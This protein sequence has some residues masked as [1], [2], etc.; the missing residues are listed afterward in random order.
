[1]IASP[2]VARG[3]EAQ[4]LSWICEF[5]RSLRKSV[6]PIWAV[7][8]VLSVLSDLPAGPLVVCVMA[9]IGTGV[10]LALRERRASALDRRPARQHCRQCG[11]VNRAE[12][13]R[14]PPA[15][16]FGAE[17]GA[18]E[19]LRQHRDDERR[20]CRRLSCL[21]PFVCHAGC[22]A[23]RMPAGLS[24]L[25]VLAAALYERQLGGADDAAEIARQVAD[26]Q[27]AAAREPGH[28]GGFP[29]QVLYLLLDLLELGDDFL[30]LG[31]HRAASY[32]RR[33][34]K[35]RPPEGGL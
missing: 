33:S 13:R 29:Q 1:M 8:P 3:L 15:V 6:T 18:P 5:R 34:P 24:G 26:V 17:R 35:K 11:L 14:L 20:R 22:G 31:R 28:V 2:R 4:C 27:G 30:L 7:G 19:H 16:R 25:A 21:L 10:F 32:A 9:A 12:L 23:S